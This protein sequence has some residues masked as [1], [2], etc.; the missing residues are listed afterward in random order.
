V[1]SINIDY[2]L[3]LDK[4]SLY[5]EMKNEFVWIVNFMKL[6]IPLGVG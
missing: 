6:P 2:A 1:G 3:S 4:A 5:S